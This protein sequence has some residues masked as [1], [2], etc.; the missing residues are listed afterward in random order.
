MISDPAW[1]TPKAHRALGETLRNEHPQFW[2]MYVKDV[3]VDNAGMF[4]GPRPTYGRYRVAPAA[5]DAVVRGRRIN[6]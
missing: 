4:S 5:M 1:G 2:N 3:R 6:Q